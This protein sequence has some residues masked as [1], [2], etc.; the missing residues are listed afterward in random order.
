M[1]SR[2]SRA[3]L[4]LALAG[5]STGLPTAAAVGAVP[6]VRGDADGSQ[7]IDIT[8]GITIFGFLFLSNPT[9]L[10]CPSAADAN[11]EGTLDISDGVYLLGFLFLGGTAPPAPYPACGTDPNP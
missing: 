8:D 11:G 10:D 3:L 6:F 9:R 1:P 2:F 5:S 7:A 4:A